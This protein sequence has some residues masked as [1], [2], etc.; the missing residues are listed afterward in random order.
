MGFA[1]QATFWSAVDLHTAVVTGICEALNR[2]FQAAHP[3]EATG[4]T[5]K[6]AGR[7]VEEDARST[8]WK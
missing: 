1:A 5:A 4:S 2:P 3:E 7:R 8:L 6:T